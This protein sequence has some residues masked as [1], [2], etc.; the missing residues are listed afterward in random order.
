MKVLY[1][2][3]SS[4]FNYHEGLADDFTAVVPGRVLDM[5]DGTPLD[6]RYYEIEGEAPDVIITFDL[7]GHVLR[8][9]SDTLSLNNIYA[10]M[11]HILFRN[12]DHYGKELTARQNLSMF[13]FVPRGTDIGLIREKLTEVWNIQ[14]FVPIERNARTDEEHAGNR[15]MTASWWEGFRRE[16]MI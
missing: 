13:T 16:A 1:L 12:A 4:K 10:K 5:A 11:A 6:K 3:N 8:T 9:G 14:E 2:I 7:A 15:E